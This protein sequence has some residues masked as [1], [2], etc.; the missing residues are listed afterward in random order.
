MRRLSLKVIISGML[1]CWSVISLG[2]EVF[3]FKFID[4]ARYRINSNVSE[5]VYV[6]TV[7]SHHADITNRITVDIS[8]VREKL[9]TEPSSALYTCTYMTSEKTGSLYPW[10]KNYESVFRRDE[11]GLYTIDVKYFMP[12]VRNIPVFPKSNVEVGES[13]TFAAHEAHDLSHLKVQ[14]PFVVPIMVTYT[15]DGTVE[16]EGK[17]LHRIISEYDLAFT[18]PEKALKKE[19]LPEQYPVATNGKSRQVLLWD[20]ETGILPE[21]SEEFMI[22]LELNT[23]ITLYFVGKAEAHITE[24]P[25][26]DKEQ[27]KNELDEALKEQGIKDTSVEVSDEGVTISLERIQFEA[28]SSRLRQSEKDKLTKIAA[29]LEKFPDH[30]LLITGHTA[31][32][33]SKSGRQV[34][35]EKR[36]ESVAGFLIELGVRT[37]EHVYTRGVGAE[38]PIAP[39][40]DEENRSRNRRVE[41]TI[42][43]R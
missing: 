39:N 31:L 33:G 26:L 28:D 10:N 36:A 42:L 4:G 32:A 3:R 29:L 40:D 35:S 7:F 30:E 17:T 19:N 43:E 22:T 14:E 27:T 23:G 18:V 21:Y 15:Y 24:M 12:T 9:G 13:W 5:D 34:L 1:I 8:D 11:L 20:N 16:K 37:K 38:K 6:N 25:K 2:A 41:I